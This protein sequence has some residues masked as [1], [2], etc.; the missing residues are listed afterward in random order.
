MKT[1]REFAM[2]IIDRHFTDAGMDIAELS[3]LI[4]AREKELSA[5]ICAFLR[6]NDLDYAATLIEGNLEVKK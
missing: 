2:Q 1:A 4:E 6:R 5:S 3:E